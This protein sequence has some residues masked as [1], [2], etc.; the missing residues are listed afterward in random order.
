MESGIPAI[1]SPT[2]SWSL[3]LSPLTHSRKVST[4]SMV[5]RNFPTGPQTWDL[6]RNWAVYALE[7]IYTLHNTLYICPKA[8]YLHPTSTVQALYI[9]HT[10]TIYT[11]DKHRTVQCS[12]RHMQFLKKC[13]PFFEK[14][15]LC[16]YNI[17]ENTVIHTMVLKKLF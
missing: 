3:V 8:P 2:T 6:H 9:H 5:G 1:L 7:M 11:P 10:Y 17:F 13:S 16:I 14:S 4:I 15:V 12:L